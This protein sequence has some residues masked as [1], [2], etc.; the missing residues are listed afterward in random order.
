VSTW[1]FFLCSTQYSLIYLLI[2]LFTEN[3]IH[4]DTHCKHINSF[5]HSLL[6]HKAAKKDK[7]NSK[8]INLK[9]V[10]LYTRSISQLLLKLRRT[11]RR[12]CSNFS[13]EEFFLCNARLDLPSKHWSRI[14]LFEIF[15]AKQSRKSHIVIIILRLRVY[16][17]IYSCVLNEIV[18]KAQTQREKKKKY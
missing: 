12:R 7:K 11:R 13:T 10:H 6:R 18:D 3:I 1:C 2:Y 5:I 15:V 17:S 14:N 8:Y 16:L 9:L 4:Y